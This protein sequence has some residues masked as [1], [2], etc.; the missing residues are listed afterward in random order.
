MTGRFGVNF[1]MQRNL[2]CI[3]KSISADIFFENVPLS[4]QPAL[5][6]VM[7]GITGSYRHLIPSFYI[8]KPSLSTP[9]E[10]TIAESF[11]SSSGKKLCG[12]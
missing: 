8:R 7:T 11:P 4:V 9:W 10:R 3:L 12:F 1:L 5:K 2:R 6:G